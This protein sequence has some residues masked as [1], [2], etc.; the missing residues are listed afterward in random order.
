MRQSIP[1]VCRPV[2]RLAAATRLDP[3]LERHSAL[4]V[5]GLG[6]AGNRPPRFGGLLAG[7][8]RRATGKVRGEKSGGVG[9]DGVWRWSDRRQPW[10]LNTLELSTAFMDLARLRFYNDVRT[11]TN[12]LESHPARSL[13]FRHAAKPLL[14]EGFYLPLPRQKL[15][16]VVSHAKTN[17]GISFQEK[18]N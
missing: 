14:P 4:V 10:V 2:A 5:L 8:F 18:A 7:V 3:R 9:A 6:G 13:N 16:S 17:L 12:N 1:S 15:T 11:Q